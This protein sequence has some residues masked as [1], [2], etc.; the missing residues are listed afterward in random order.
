MEEVAFGILEKKDAPAA[1]GRPGLFGELDAALFEFGFGVVQG[2]DAERDMPPA[3]DVVDGGLGDGGF[4]GVNLDH[5]VPI[6][7]QERHGRVFKRD[8]RAEDADV[9]VFQCLWIA[10][11]QAEMFDGELHRRSVG[12]IGEKGTKFLFGQTALKR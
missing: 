11:G 5:D 8:A 7:A 2:I 10:C 3:G 4:A 1:A 9:P 12:R 6:Q